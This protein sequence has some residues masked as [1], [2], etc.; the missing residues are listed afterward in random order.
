MKVFNFLSSGKK[1]RRKKTAKNRRWLTKRKFL[2]AAS[3]LVL[4]L[5]AMYILFLDFTVRTRF[6]GRRF[7]LPARVYARPLELYTGLKLAPSELVAELELLGYRETTSPRESGSY[8]WRNQQVE[9]VTRPFTYG[10]GPQESS[11]LRV[12]FAGDRVTAL[13]GRAD[14]AAIELLRLDPALIGGIYPGNNEDRVL[15]R[16]DEVP[17]LLVD[18]LIAV[19]DVRFYS[20]RGIDPRGIARALVMTVSGKSVQGGSTLTQQLVKNFFLS[21]ERTVRRKLNEMVMALLLEVHYSKEEILETYLNEVYLG[22]DGNRA[23]HGF[24]LASSFFFDKPLMQIDLPEA[25]L[26]VGMLKGPTYYSPRRHSQ[27]ALDR[28]NL[29]LGEM[30]EARFIT[31]QQLLAGRITPLGVVDRPPRGISPYPAFLSLVHRQLRRDY[32][33]EDLRSEGLQIFTTLDPW[34]QRSAE[35]ALSQQLKRLEQGRGIATDSLQGALL[36]TDAQNGEVQAVV[37]GRDPRFEGFNRA[38]DAQRPIGSLIKPVVF[39]TA[40]QQPQNYTL[41]TLLDD[42]PL[43]LQQPGTDDWQPQNYD[44]KFHDQVPLHSALAHSYNVSTARLGLQLGLSSVLENLQRLGIDRQLPGYAA[45]LLGADTFSPLEVAQLYQT[46]ASGGFR[47]PLR[48]IREVLTFAGQPLQRYPLKVEQ[49]VDVSSNFLLTVALQEVVQQGT[50]R[51][52]HR[53]LPAELNLAGKTG[54]TDEFRDSWFAGFSGDRLGVVW[55]GRD[56]NQPA[57]LTGAS[58]AMTIWAE[59]MVGLDLEPLILPIPDSIEHVWIES[60]SGLRSAAGCPDA[61]E[62]PFVTG[63]APTESTSCGPGSMGNPIKSWFERIFK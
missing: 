21:A 45:S 2:L 33:D 19:E 9:L 18:A 6:E 7:A 56:D 52:L 54:T 49:V 16:L 26:L 60:K 10:D 38:L 44:K 50:A 47:I 55:V 24:G 4:L 39:L 58:G 62:L 30:A 59:M 34:V 12:S 36:V 48:A 32:R 15:V 20:H 37:G 5:A 63:S 22:Q 51:G 41:A 11:S 40:L 8:Q 27:R 42:S 35:K 61:V 53:Y 43:L 1:T 31:D 28:R 46:L 57:G 23:I 25:A 13:Q 14:N 17:Q 29:V 3:L